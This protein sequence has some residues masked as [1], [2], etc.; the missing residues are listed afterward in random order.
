MMGQIYE[1]KQYANLK[2]FEHSF[3]LLENT[4]KCLKAYMQQYG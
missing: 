1:F 4:R 3:K 2:N